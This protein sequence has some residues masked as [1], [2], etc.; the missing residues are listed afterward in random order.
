MTDDD[1]FYNNNVNAFVVHQES[2]DASLEAGAFQLECIWAVPL[3]HGGTSGLHRKLVRFDELTLDTAQQRAYYYDFDKAKALRKSRME[4]ELD[5]LRQ[6]F[7]RM[8]EERSIYGEEGRAA[9]SALKLRFAR[10]GVPLVHYPRDLPF[11]LLQGLYSAKLGKPFA[12][13]RKLLVESAHQMAS[14][15]SMLR[16]FSQ[17][18]RHYGRGDQLKSED[19]SG[20]WAL[21][22]KD[23]R[24][25]E[26]QDPDAFSP[27]RTHQTLVE[28][29]FPEL[30]PL[31]VCVRPSHLDRCNP[32]KYELNSPRP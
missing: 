6:D 27:D 16:W 5:Q 13:K 14:R 21:K 19:R 32:V 7:E 12:S 20:L 24:A 4:A 17:A 25:Q 31:S 1:V 2:V 23:L 9:W 26:A 15:K 18:L 11:E 30:C 10:V 8:F 22:V 28:F 3:A 29:L